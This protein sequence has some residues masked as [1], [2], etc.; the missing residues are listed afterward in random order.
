MSGFIRRSKRTVYENPW[1][2]FEAY[3]IVHPSGHAGEHGLVWVP[4]AVAVVALDGEDVHLVLI[5]TGSEN[6]TPPPKSTS[7]AE[8]RLT[9]DAASRKIPKARG[10]GSDPRI[11]RQP[12][13]GSTSYVA[14]DRLARA[15]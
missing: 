9:N 11:G 15:C 7:M 4:P 14:L 3:E 6:E 8:S 1:I 12:L 2:R 10:G 13:P 5:A